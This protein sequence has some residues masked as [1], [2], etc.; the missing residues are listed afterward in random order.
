MAANHR[1]FLGGGTGRMLG[2][3]LYGHLKFREVS[4]EVL[5]SLSALSV[6]PSKEVCNSIWML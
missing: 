6:F 2:N 1:S 3:L 5:K 4:F